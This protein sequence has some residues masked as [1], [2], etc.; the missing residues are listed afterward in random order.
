MVARIGEMIAY[1]SYNTK[2]PLNGE[3]AR[4]VEQN[5]QQLPLDPISLTMD[6]SNLAA[7]PQDP[8]PQAFSPV[9]APGQADLPM[10]PPPEMAVPPPLPAPRPILRPA[11][12]PTAIVVECPACGTRYRIPAQTA[13]RHARCKNCQGIIDIPAPLAES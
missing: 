5:H 6:D 9:P 1:Q 3:A 11:A 12:A 10:A 13:A 2:S 8:A 7:G 4:W